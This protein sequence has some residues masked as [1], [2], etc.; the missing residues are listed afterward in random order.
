MLCCRQF[1]N[2][3]YFHKTSI[4]EK[5]SLRI[6]KLNVFYTLYYLLFIY[7][8]LDFRKNCSFRLFLKL[9]NLIYTNS[10]KKSQV[11]FK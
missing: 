10:Y 6:F 8:Y 5:Y 9:I 1:N 3:R 2:L 7:I 11:S 4:T